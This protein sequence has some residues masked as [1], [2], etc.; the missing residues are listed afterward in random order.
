MFLGDVQNSIK[1]IYPNVLFTKLIYSTLEKEEKFTVNPNPEINQ[2]VKEDNSQDI[3][4]KTQ[5]PSNS[6]ETDVDMTSVEDNKKEQN[7]GHFCR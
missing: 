4:P 2:N 7:N 5:L 1:G 3:S 6:V